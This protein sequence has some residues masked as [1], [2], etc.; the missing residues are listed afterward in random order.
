[1]IHP[2]IACNVPN[3]DS[4][5]TTDELMSFWNE[6]QDGRNYRNL[7]PAGGKGTKSAAANLAC[8][9]SNKATAI[10]CRL[11]GEIE[12]ALMYEGIADRIYSNLPD[13]ARW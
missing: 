1:M 10:Q 3:L 11:R 12:T 7:F 9:A 8:Y 5:L 2:T 13:Y 6:Y 4:G